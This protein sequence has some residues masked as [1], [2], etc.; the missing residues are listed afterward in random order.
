MDSTRPQRRDRRSSLVGV[1]GLVVAIALSQ[2]AAAT[3]MLY[4]Y[5]GNDFT[6]YYGSFSSIPDIGENVTIQFEADPASLPGGVAAFSMTCGGI[7][8]N[9]GN[10]DTYG[11]VGY[12]F[13]MLSG[14]P[15]DWSFYINPP[16]PRSQWTGYY[17]SSSCTPSEAP[18][19]YADDGVST[20]ASGFWTGD[21]A[22][23]DN[24][25]GAWTA[26]PVAAVP[27]PPPAVIMVTSLIPLAWALRRRGWGK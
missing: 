14:L 18:G 8:I 22:T 13:I 6:S 17:M 23:V 11:D 24:D 26:T 7:T 27:L 9:G 25:P 15:Y 1:V 2:P 5:T 3:L 12:V 19:F 16:E 20:Y 10:G 4:T 21:G